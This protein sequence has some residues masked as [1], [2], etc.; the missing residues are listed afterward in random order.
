M[1]GS[2]YG[3]RGPRVGDEF[4]D[5]RLPDQTGTVVGLHERR[6]GRRAVVAFNRS[7]VW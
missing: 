2:D 1:S 7:V 6:D 4:P 5:I 3:E